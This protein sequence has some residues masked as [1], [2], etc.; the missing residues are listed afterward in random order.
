MCCYCKCCRNIICVVVLIFKGSLLILNEVKLEKN[1]KT[2]CTKAQSCTALWCCTPLKKCKKFYFQ[3][4]PQIWH[5]YTEKGFYLKWSGCYSLPWVFNLDYEV[6]FSTAHNHTHTHH[7]MLCSAERR[8][9][10]SQNIFNI[11]H[12]SFIFKPLN[13]TSLRITR[14]LA[15]H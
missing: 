1:E 6:N 7:G 9:S 4:Q 14:M 5:I 15:P 11:H 10:V 8:T 12:M 3:L 13:K 2:K